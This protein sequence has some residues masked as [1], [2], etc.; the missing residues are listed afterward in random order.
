MKY[1]S[2]QDLESIIER[3]CGGKCT[4]Q[5]IKL[6]LFDIREFLAKDSPLGDIADCIHS[7][8]NREMLYPE[9]EVM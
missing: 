7:T 6:M 3:I 4:R 8:R 9:L 5:D 2:K 1:S